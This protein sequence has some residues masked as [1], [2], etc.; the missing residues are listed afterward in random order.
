MIRFVLDLIKNK[1]AILSNQEEIHYTK[2][3]PKPENKLDSFNQQYI[4]KFKQYASDLQNLNNELKQIKEKLENEK[5]E[6]ENKVMSNSTNNKI[7]SSNCE[8][9]EDLNKSLSLLSKDAKTCLIEF[10]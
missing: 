3:N 4:E 7:S 2:C 6:V 9:N 1:N 5:D 10:I 8:N